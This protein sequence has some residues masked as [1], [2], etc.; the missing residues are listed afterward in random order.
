MRAPRP[1]LGAIAVALVAACGGGQTSLYNGTIQS[2]S[3]TY[4]AAN[5]GVGAVL[6]AAAG[7]CKISGCPTNT[8]CNQITER[9]DPVKCGA[10]D[11]KADEAC[12]EQSGECVPVSWLMPKASTNVPPVPSGAT[13][14]PGT[15]P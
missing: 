14:G 11:C 12:D 1:L 6:Y 4:A 13:T 5:V 10:T 2:S 15:L 9:C 7:G 3:A 8:Q